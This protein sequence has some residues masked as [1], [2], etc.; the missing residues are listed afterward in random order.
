MMFQC[1]YQV[2]VD[3]KIASGVKILP[4]KSCNYGTRS[5]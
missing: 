4:D 1:L 3:P 5:P 2:R